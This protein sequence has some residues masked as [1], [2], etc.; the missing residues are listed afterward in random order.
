MFKN[1]LRR[2]IRCSKSGSSINSVICPLVSSIAFLLWPSAS[3]SFVTL[4][5]PTLPRGTTR[6]HADYSFLSPT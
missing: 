6:R 4:G 3:S 1:M 5:D 2:T